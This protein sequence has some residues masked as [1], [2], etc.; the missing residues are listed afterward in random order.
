MLDLVGS[1]AYETEGDCLRALAQIEDKLASGAYT[2]DEHDPYNLLGNIESWAGLMSFPV[3]RTYAPESPMRFVTWA[4]NVPATL[5][6]AAQP[7]RTPLA[8]VRQTIGAAD[9]AIGVN[10]P[11]GVSVSLTWT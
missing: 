6:R 11:W 4:Q 1:Y 9:F 2:G 3:I 8:W 7:L 5:W 10:F